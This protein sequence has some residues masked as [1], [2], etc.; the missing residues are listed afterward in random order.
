MQTKEKS[1]FD[2]QCIAGTDSFR[3]PTRVPA[4]LHPA[5]IAAIMDFQP[6]PTCPT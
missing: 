6:T 4:R 1:L 3:Q 5:A 2:I